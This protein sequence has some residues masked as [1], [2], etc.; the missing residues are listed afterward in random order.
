MSTSVRG[1]NTCEAT[2]APIEQTTTPSPPNSA[3]GTFTRRAD[4]KVL[5][6]AP[7]ADR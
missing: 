3:L 2:T 1:S 6:D 5:G 7:P 4:S